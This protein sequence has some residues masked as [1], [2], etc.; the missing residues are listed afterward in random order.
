[1][2][3]FALPAFADN[4]IWLLPCSAG[5]VVVDPGVADGV[6]AYLR[7]SG[8]QLHAIL[9]THHH[10]DHIG[11]TPELLAAFPQARV[12]GP[13]DRRIAT[14]TEHVGE[15]DCVQLGDELTLRVMEVPGHTLT[16]IAFYNDTDLYC[17]DTLFSLGC[18]RLFEGS[19]AQMLASLSR[20]AALDPRTR[21]YCGHEYTLANGR[22]ASAV[23]PDNRALIEYLA[24]VRSQRAVDE[25]SLPS[26][27]KD[28][29]HC[30][31]FLRVDEPKL[32]DAV[33]AHAGRALI[34]RVDMFGQL[35]AWKDVSA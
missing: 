23:E 11:G 16:H 4:Y 28:E 24:R 32:I 7:A 12:V 15:G 10:H 35:R 3:A 2:P 31:P 5:A 9:L 17:G 25:P 33:S 18:G 19:P 8:L 27:L 34:D 14:V 30:N 21:V 22:F 26:V 13:R 29:L 20:I 1:M 6:L